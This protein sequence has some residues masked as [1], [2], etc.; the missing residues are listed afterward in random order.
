MV[1]EKIL[2]SPFYCKEIH[3]VNSKGNQSYIFNGRTE[4]ETQIIWAHDEKNWLI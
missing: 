1:L 4:A 3:P 2:V